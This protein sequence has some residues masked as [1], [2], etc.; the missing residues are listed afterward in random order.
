M[1]GL[2]SPTALQ[3]AAFYVVGKMFCLRGGAEHRE[4]KK[5]HTVYCHTIRSNMQ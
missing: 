2:N 4:L 3:N 5:S 1:C